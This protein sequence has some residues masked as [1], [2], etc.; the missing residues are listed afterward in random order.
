M[1]RSHRADSGG[2]GS[3]TTSRKRHT[4]V[5]VSSSDE[6]SLSSS[7]SSSTSSESDYSESDDDSSSGDEPLATA[8]LSPARSRTAKQRKS[9]TTNT[10]KGKG[11]DRAEDRASRDKERERKRR[12]KERRNKRAKKRAKRRHRREHEAADRSGNRDWLASH[13][14]ALVEW[15]AED[16]KRIRYFIHNRFDGFAR[17]ER[18]H[19]GKEAIRHV[20]GSSTGLKP[21]KCLAIIR[22]HVVTLKGIASRVDRSLSETGRAYTVQQLKAAYD[23]AVAEQQHRLA[24]ALQRDVKTIS[25]AKEQYS[26]IE[27][28]MDFLRQRPDAPE[29]I[30]E[31]GGNL[32]TPSNARTTDVVGNATP[33]A[34]PRCAR[35]RV[36]ARARGARALLISPVRI[37]P[38]L[39]PSP[40]PLTLTVPPTIWRLRLS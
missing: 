23:D 38:A 5:T 35:T 2:A 21:S 4:D 11:K 15:I 19:L 10:P 33:A 8:S 29:N 6:D 26:W 20:W 28:M 13:N 16:S 39:I 14:V 36:C 27:S 1:P 34:V 17:N 9:T 30:V 40:S 18:S 12:R 25:D 24:S 32:N 3:S 7:E 22:G 31:P 37:H